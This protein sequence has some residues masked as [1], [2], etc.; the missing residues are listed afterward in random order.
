MNEYEKEDTNVDSCEH[1]G[2]VRIYEI[3]NIENWIQ[4]DT[5]VDDV[6]DETDSEKTTEME[7]DS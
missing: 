5:T 4:S 1:S 2:D 6:L 3:D 7:S